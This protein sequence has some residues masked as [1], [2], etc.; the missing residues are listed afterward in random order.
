MYMCIQ[1][2]CLHVYSTVI[3]LITYMYIVICV[4]IIYNG[5]KFVAR[6]CLLCMW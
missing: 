2:V 4:H 1:S 3:M 5:M 6:S